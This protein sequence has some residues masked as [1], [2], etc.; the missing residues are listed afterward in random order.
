MPSASPSAPAPPFAGPPGS[1]PTPKTAATRTATEA[2]PAADSRR[3][4]GRAAAAAC[5]CET[6][7]CRRTTPIPPGEVLCRVGPQHAHHLPGGPCPGPDRGPCSDPDW[8]PCRSTPGGYAPE[9][10]AASSSSRAAPLG[11]EGLGRFMGQGTGLGL[12]RGH[13][14]GRV[15]GSA[16]RD[17]PPSPRPAR[18]AAARPVPGPRRPSTGGRRQ[19][20]P[21]KPAAAGAAVRPPRCH[22]ASA[23]MAHDPPP[24]RAS[25][26]RSAMT[27]SR[28]SRSSMSSTACRATGS[29]AR[30]CTASA[31]WPGAGRHRWGSRAS[32]RGPTAPGAAS[33][34]GQH[35]RVQLA[36]LELAQAGVHVA[37]DRHEGRI[38]PPGGAGPRSGGAIPFLP[39]RPGAR[40]LVGRSTPHGHRPP[41]PR[42]RGIVP[43]RARRQDQVRRLLAGQV[44]KAVDGHIY[45]A[46]AQGLLRGPTRDAPLAKPGQRG[47]PVEIAFG[48]DFPQD[49]A[50]RQPVP[51]CRRLQL[52]HHPTGLPKGQ[53]AGARPTTSSRGC[54]AP[55][56]S[57]TAGARSKARVLPSAQP[58]LGLGPQFLLHAKEAGRG[59]GKP[60]A[61]GRG[62]LLL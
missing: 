27:A 52:R 22:W 38:G 51:V 13:S 43:H 5:G 55:N 8:G 37:P 10:P 47:L 62:R 54:N 31:P 36:A 59:I 56:S 7:T 57:P 20:R 2:R 32:A 53:G 33:G 50:Q 21:P 48:A 19:G 39:G 61:L 15:P 58:P 30:T 9:S 4:G 6:P 46:P 16:G 26:S 25:S 49:K 41:P 60:L 40:R 42:P 35:H 3:F 17:G 45:L 24:S 29:S 44:L 11:E 1:R 28:T 18:R 34:S 14:L 12:G 23:P